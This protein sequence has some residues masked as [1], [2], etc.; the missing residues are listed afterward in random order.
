MSKFLSI[1]LLTGTTSTAMVALAQQAMLKVNPVPIQ[2]TSTASRQQMYTS[3]CAAC[4]GTNGTGNGPAA[5]ALKVP[6]TDLTM[7]S[8]KNGGVL[9]A[10]HLNAVLKF[11]VE[12]PAHGSAEMPTWGNM[13]LSLH[14]GSA[15]PDV[16]VRQRIANLTEYL[17]TI[18][19]E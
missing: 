10:N 5:S 1:F 12:N 2:Q 16:Q 4:H 7:L 17:R 3:Y 9:P 15:N 8:R 6:P 14:K 19:K 11:G 18:Q 13:M